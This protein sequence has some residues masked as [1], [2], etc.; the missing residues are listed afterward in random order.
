MLLTTYYII[1]VISSFLFSLL[2]TGAMYYLLKKLSLM[3]MP[4]DRSNHKEPVPTGAGL[5]FMLTT[6]GFLVVANAPT[7]IWSGALLLCIISFID[8]MRSLGIVKRL[9]AQLVAVGLAVTVFPEPVFQG[10]LPEWA[11]LA[12][13]GLLWLWFI[14]LYNFMDGIDG[15]TVTQSLGMAIGISLLSFFVD[16]VPRAL[17]VDALIIAAGL[18]AFIPWNMHPAKLFM[19]DSGSVTL[20]FL[21]GYLLLHLAADGYWMAALILPSY[22]LL[23][24]SLTLL[25]RILA[26]KPFW[27]A[28]SEHYYQ[29]AVRGGR[30]HDQV[31][32]P[33]MWLNLLMVVLALVS[34]Q[35][36]EQG[37]IA[38]ATAYA[39][40]LFLLLRFTQPV[41][42]KSHEIT[43]SA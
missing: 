25:K 4:V 39:C 12:L 1:L 3:D 24:A 23:D 13:T 17:S 26:G 14:N 34:A 2:A 19:G 31:T 21:F 30:S 42:G 7:P 9:G 33:L 35:E 11:D 38:L 43:H 15:I 37:W 20:G 41:R 6:T 27:R 5:G 8:D 32:V 10:L 28:H 16:G 18:I 40:S 22:Y 29:K 36:M